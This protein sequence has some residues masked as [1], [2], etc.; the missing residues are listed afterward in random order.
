[1]KK[2]KKKKRKKKQKKKLKPNF[3][4]DFLKK[5]LHFFNIKVSQAAFK[6]FATQCLLLIT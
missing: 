5:I 4:H 2:K 6:S 1:M 3:C